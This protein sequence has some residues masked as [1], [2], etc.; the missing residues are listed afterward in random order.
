MEV[1]FGYIKHRCPSNKL[2]WRETMA[3]GCAFFSPFSQRGVAAAAPTLVPVLSF[4][5]FLREMFGQDKEAVSQTRMQLSRPPTFD[6]HL[7][8]F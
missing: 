6:H 1:S 7:M 3:T 5:A 2:T 8:M 4:S